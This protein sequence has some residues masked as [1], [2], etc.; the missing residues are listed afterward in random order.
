MNGWVMRKYSNVDKGFLISPF[1]IF[2]LVFI[3]LYP[4]DILF[5][6]LIIVIGTGYII[7]TSN[8]IMTLNGLYEKTYKFTAKENNSI[9]RHFKS[10]TLINASLKRRIKIH[11]LLFP[12]L[13]I[14]SWRTYS[15]IDKSEVSIYI[16]IYPYANLL[17]TR[18]SP[19][20]YEIFSQFDDLM[21]N[22]FFQA[23]S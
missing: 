23:I 13:I 22:N 1:I 11:D 21:E 8:H 16:K 17:Q 2:I 6:F 7:C 18:M 15:F 5:I 10:I 20:N 12:S 3:Y 4:T 19:D 14:P 9:S